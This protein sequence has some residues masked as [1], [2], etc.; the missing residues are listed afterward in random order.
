MESHF[1]TSCWGHGEFNEDFIA[2][3]QKSLQNDKVINNILKKFDRYVSKWFDFIDISFLP[4]DMKVAYKE[5]IAGR[6][7]K[8]H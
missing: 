7:G 3:M 2:A 8:L 6:I 5:L 4:D 1:E